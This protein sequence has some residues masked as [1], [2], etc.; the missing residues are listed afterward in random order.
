MTENRGFVAM[1]PT[2]KEDSKFDYTLKLRF[3]GK[4]L[5]LEIRLNSLQEQDS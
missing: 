5:I 4:E 1:I 2:K 3:F